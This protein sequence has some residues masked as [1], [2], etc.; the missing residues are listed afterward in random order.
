MTI[1][2]PPS[3][4]LLRDRPSAKVKR[5][6]V[7]AIAVLALAGVLGFVAGRAIG[8][9]L[10]RWEYASAQRHTVAPPKPDLPPDPFASH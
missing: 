6:T 5:A 1:Q 7:A 9:T 10:G 4:Q 2:L 8:P 3:T